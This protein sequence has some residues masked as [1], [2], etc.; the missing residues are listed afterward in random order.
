MANAKNE[1]ITNNLVDPRYMQNL[2]LIA[3]EIEDQR[4]QYPDIPFQ[5]G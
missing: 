2:F 5:L 4:S 3:H 1:G